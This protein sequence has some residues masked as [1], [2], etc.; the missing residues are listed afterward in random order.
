MFRRILTGVVLTVTPCVA[1]PIALP[2]SAAAGASLPAAVQQCAN[3]GW[4]TLT[5]ASGQPFKNQGQCIS[6]AILHPVSLADL[7]SASPFTGTPTL[8]FQ[9]NGCEF[10][11]AFDAIYPG[12]TAVGNVDLHIAGC[13]ASSLTSYAGSFTIAT[14]VGT[15]SGNASGSLT[16]SFGPDDQPLLTFQ[17]TLSVSAGSGSFA[18][19]T[20]SMQFFT[21][22]EPADTPTSFVGSVTVA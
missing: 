19:T 17:L 2:A 21:S 16:V 11:A 8:G 4:R 18:G 14:D 22:W 7:A 6:Y 9:I 13:I 1:I 20:G 12:S 10:D 5:N 3:G 15:T